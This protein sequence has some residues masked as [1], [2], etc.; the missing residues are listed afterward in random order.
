MKTYQ[1]LVEGRLL[2]VR[3]YVAPQCFP[4][5]CR[6]ATELAGLLNTEVGFHMSLYI[7]SFLARFMAD[8]TTPHF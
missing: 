8:K 2:M 7:P 3:F 6:F 4:V 5:L 1:H